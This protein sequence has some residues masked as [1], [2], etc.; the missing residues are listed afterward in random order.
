M[1]A[2]NR[3]GVDSEAVMQSCSTFLVVAQNIY[4][5]DVKIVEQRI[6][7][8]LGGAVCSRTAMIG[9]RIPFGTMKSELHMSM[10]RI[11]WT[12]MRTKYFGC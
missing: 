5:E 10:K 1:K 12:E 9:K 3:E 11:Q 2:L 8:N 7:K 4:R 6:W